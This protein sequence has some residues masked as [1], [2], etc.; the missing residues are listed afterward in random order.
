MIALLRSWK[1]IAAM[2]IAALAISA[3][4]TKFAITKLY[5]AEAILRPISQLMPNGI[6][7]SPTSTLGSSLLGTTLAQS[8]AEEIVAT[9]ESLDFGLALVGRHKLQNELLA[10]VSGWSRGSDPQWDVLRLL[11]RSFNCEYSLSTGNITMSYLDPSRASARRYLSYY[12]DD[13]RAKLREEQIRTT[14][15]AIE[16]L[17]DA[18]RSTPDSLLATQLYQLVAQELQEQKL[19]LV[20]ADFAFKVIETPAASDRPYSPNV[21]MVAGL[22]GIVTLVLSCL[23]LVGRDWMQR[24]RLTYERD[25]APVRRRDTPATR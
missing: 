3:A 25:S 20:D 5:R 10:K 12:V 4:G 22:A 17:Q 1:L 9:L 11:Q 13:L 14:G 8:R 19:A 23:I 15:A 24:I 21:L 2:T 7:S 6:S 16:S 18:A